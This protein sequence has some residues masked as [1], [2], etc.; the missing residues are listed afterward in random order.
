MIPASLL[1][2]NSLNWYAFR[3]NESREIVYANELFE[4]YADHIQPKH[5]DD[6]LKIEKDREK[7]EAAMEKAKTM[8]PF[9]VPVSFRLLQNTGAYRW[10]VWEVS[11][12]DG[13]H[14]WLGA[15]LFDV[16]SIMGH[17]Y[18]EL[19]RVHEKICW[20]HSHKV[21][22]PLSNI[23]GIVGLMGKSSGASVEELVPMLEKSAKE[24]DEAIQSVVNFASRRKDS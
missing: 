21:R 23:L 22:R 2:E 17:Q 9:P 11:Y 24:L 8:S 14:H 5:I 4:S 20:M 18:E 12:G 19:T 13:I 15:Q 10:S 3:T 1:L 16:V 6:L 7:V